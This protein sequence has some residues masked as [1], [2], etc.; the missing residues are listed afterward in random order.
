MTLHAETQGSGPAL[1][2]LH[3]WGLHSG[4]W[5]PVLPRLRQHFRVTC[6]DLPGH[7]GSR[8]WDEGFDLET[9]AAAALEAA[10]RRAAW[11][12]WSLGGQVTLAADATDL[13]SGETVS[14]VELE[15]LSARWVV[16]S[17]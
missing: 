17:R 4:I 12:G 13:L 1:V 5:E 8:G 3:G 2:M 7:G 6:I 9:A 16:L 14:V 15:P 10:P 11:L